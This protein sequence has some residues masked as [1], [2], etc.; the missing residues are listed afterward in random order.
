MYPVEQC[1]DQVHWPVQPHPT[2]QHLLLIQRQCDLDKDKAAAEPG[3]AR[4][5][6]EDRQRAINEDF[7]EMQRADALRGPD[8][9]DSARGQGK[10]RKRI[11]GVCSFVNI[12]ERL[13]KQCSTERR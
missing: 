4:A 10:D 3:A 2:M 5:D 12:T 7:R 13:M 8:A 1:P 6:L 9:E 11:F